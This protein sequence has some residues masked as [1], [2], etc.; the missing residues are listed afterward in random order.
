MLISASASISVCISW[1]WTGIL[2]LFHTFDVVL[3]GCGLLGCLLGFASATREKTCRSQKP[4]SATRA[5]W[6]SRVFHICS[7]LKFTQCRSVSVQGWNWRCNRCYWCWCIRLSSVAAAK[8]ATA[9]VYRP[10]VHFC[11]PHSSRILFCLSGVLFEYTRVGE[12]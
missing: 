7:A 3:G 12:V 2:T 4:F 11:E 5:N 10:P 6:L 9:G 1:V 8:V